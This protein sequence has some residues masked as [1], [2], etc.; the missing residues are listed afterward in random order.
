MRPY[1]QLHTSRIRNSARLVG[2]ARPEL[3][4]V[5]HDFAVEL[6]ARYP[7]L[8]DMRFLRGDCHTKNALAGADALALIDLDQAAVG[9][10]AADIGSLLARLRMGTIVGERSAEA[11]C[12]LRQ[13]FLSG[14]GLVAPLPSPAVLN[15]YTA[16]TMLVERAIRAVNRV[17]VEA[18]D[19]LDE[20][21]NGAVASLGGGTI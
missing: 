18:L 12:A 5:L 9:P 3:A 20:V 14:Y 17:Q 11:E 13:M 2:M 21:V 1:R 8:D 4:R 6:L 15:W 19:H 16:A 7:V 10:A